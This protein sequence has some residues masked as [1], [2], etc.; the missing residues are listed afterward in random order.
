MTDREYVTLKEYIDTKIDA[1]TRLSETK[2]GA[3]EKAT[4]LAKETIDNRL[5]NMNE[6]RDALKDSTALNVTR[7]EMKSL[8][9][10][11]SDRVSIIE[12]N[13]A[14]LSGKASQKALDRVNNVAIAG[15][16]IGAFGI[17]AA[18]ISLVIHIP[19]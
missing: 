1:L 5:A 3:V 9:K 10:T 19:K 2:I 4:I 8:E 11:L 13:N 15:I 7:I 17:I 12:I 18:I 16:I 14:T 6:F